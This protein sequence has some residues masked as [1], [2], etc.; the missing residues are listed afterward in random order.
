MYIL[1][2]HTI[3]LFTYIYTQVYGDLGSTRSSQNPTDDDDNDSSS[4]NDNGDLF[5]VKGSTSKYDKYS[6]LNT[7]DTNTIYG[8]KLDQILTKWKNSLNIH[9]SSSSH[10]TAA[11]PTTINRFSQIKERCVTGSWSGQNIGQRVKSSRSA[12]N[13]NTK[14]NNGDNSSDEGENEEEEGEDIY[15]DYEDLET[16]QKFGPNSSTKGHN[17]DDYEEGSDS[18]YDYDYSNNHS[19]NNSDNDDEEEGQNYDQDEDDEDDIDAINDDI[20]DQLL[21]SQNA[22][23]KQ[24]FKTQFDLSYDNNKHNSSGEGEEGENEGVEGKKGRSRLSDQGI[25]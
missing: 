24:S 10:S 8:N 12:N 13:S 21:R 5:I 6:R 7:R 19:D 14:N 22:K 18:E 16:G 20:D 2:T 11:T 1:L 3:T 4:D 15:G 17:S 25:I 23:K 9:T